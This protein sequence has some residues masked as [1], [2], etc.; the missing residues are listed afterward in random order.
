MLSTFVT[1]ILATA[2]AIPAATLVIAVT[3]AAA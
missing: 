3:A 1:D 2:A